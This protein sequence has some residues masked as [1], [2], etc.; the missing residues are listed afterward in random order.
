MA[1]PGETVS[2]LC[3][4][5]EQ[6]ADE[7]G[8]DAGCHG[9]IVVRL[10][11]VRLRRADSA[12]AC[13][14]ETSATDEVDDRVF[15]YRYDSLDRVDTAWRHPVGSTTHGEDWDYGYHDASNITRRV[16]DSTTTHFAY[17]A[18][19]QLCWTAAT[20]SGNACDN[21]PSGAAGNVIRDQDYDPYG[22][23]IG[24]TST[25]SYSPRF[26]FAG[27]I[28]DSTTGLYHYGQRLYDPAI[29][30]W[31]QPDPLTQ[32]ADLRQSN[33]YAYSACN[34]VNHADPSGLSVWDYAQECGEGAVSG[35]LFGALTGSVA[36]AAAGAVGGCVEGLAEQ[37]AT[38]VYGPAV[39]KT[40]GLVGGFGN[41]YDLAKQYGP[42]AYR[43][44][45]DWFGAGA[46]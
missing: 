30:R 44:T 4:Y 19:N 21:A 46:Y 26:A 11:S 1:H 20:G 29:G 40:V 35:A 16:H 14:S 2:V 5:E 33:R 42:R 27:G 34:P 41:G 22:S 7:D 6:Q 3:Y 23:V 25:G 24:A 12:L 13:A 37:A 8:Y 39:G 17:T 36:G 18:N 38:D 28:T 9:S 45:Y 43:A 31:T 10:A 15:E 32:M